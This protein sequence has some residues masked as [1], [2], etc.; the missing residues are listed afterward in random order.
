M[1][2]RKIRWIR[3]CIAAIFISVIAIRIIYVNV[4]YPYAGIIYKN[5]DDNF[6]YKSEDFSIM[7]GK[8]YTKNDWLSYLKENDIEDETEKYK[9]MYSGLDDDKNIKNYDYSVG[10]NPEADYKVLVI[11]IKFTSDYAGA[12]KRYVNQSF[13]IVSKVNSAALF[14]D[15]YYSSALSEMEED[16]KVYVGVYYMTKDEDKLYLS[17]V[18][19]GNCLM[20]DL[21][22]VY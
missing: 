15:D 10:Y 22:G 13:K 20:I 3:I 6:T 17:V 18:D 5:I 8:I 19:L 4:K 21:K 9:V 1:R 11:K 2:S 14:N 12:L 7:T 16:N